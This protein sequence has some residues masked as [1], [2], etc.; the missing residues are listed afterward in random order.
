MQPTAKATTTPQR[1]LKILCIHGFDT[2]HEIMAKQLSSWQSVFPYLEFIPLD[3]PYKLLVPGYPFGHDDR[4]DSL[5]SHS[6]FSNIEAIVEHTFNMHPFNREKDSD[7]KSQT[8]IIKNTSGFVQKIKS[9]GGV[10]NF[11]AP[12]PKMDF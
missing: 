5:S 1:K 10:G 12:N 11:S 9:L 3:G 4:L 6:T 2:N 8:S 7:R